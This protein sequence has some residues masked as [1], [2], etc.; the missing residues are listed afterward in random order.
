MHVEQCRSSGRRNET[1]RIVWGWAT[2]A[3]A[4]VML[5]K[6]DVRIK[7]KPTSLAC[8]EGQ[9][10]DYEVGFSLAH[11]STTTKRGQEQDLRCPLTLPAGRSAVWTSAK[12]PVGLASI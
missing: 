12:K 2:A 5:L 3:L 9:L 11:D 4:L 1:R 7:L 8:S 10:P 6:R